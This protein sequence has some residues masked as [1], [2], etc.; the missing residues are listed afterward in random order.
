VRKKLA[1][2]VCSTG[3]PGIFCMRCT[4]T[5][6]RRSK[7]AQRQAWGLHVPNSTLFHRI[8]SL[9]AEEEELQR[10]R[11]SARRGLSPED[12]RKLKEQQALADKMD[13]EEEARQAA[14]RRQRG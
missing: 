6:T 2:G 11:L 5:H 7:Q 13:A 8:T 3:V 14:M 12:M 10:S 1:P 9:N 4:T